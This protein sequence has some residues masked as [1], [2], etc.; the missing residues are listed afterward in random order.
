MR[1]AHWRSKLLSAASTPPAPARSR[2]STLSSH[3]SHLA[4]SRRRT[5]EGLATNPLY[6]RHPPA[7]A[8]AISQLTK[9]TVPKEDASTQTTA[10]QPL[11]DVL[12]IGREPN[13]IDLKKFYHDL[14]LPAKPYLGTLAPQ[15]PVHLA[16][17]AVPDSIPSGWATSTAYSPTA[18]SASYP[19]PPPLAA[20]AAPLGKWN[21]DD[22]QTV[23]MAGQEGGH[24]YEP[25]PQ[26]VEYTVGVVG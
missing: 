2:T 23:V 6:Q 14:A 13:P 8:P 25:Y 10:P 20:A 7:A 19:S 12:T 3:T 17:V 15:Q 9:V 16:A 24:G 22:A 1:E 11:P 4:S 5:L 18:T 21:T 26:L